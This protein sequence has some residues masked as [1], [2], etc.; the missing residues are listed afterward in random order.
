[1][2]F[3]LGVE[4][5]ERERRDEKGR[6]A[7]PAPSGMRRRLPFI[8]AQPLALRQGSLEPTAIPLS[9]LLDCLDVLEQKKR[10]EKAQ[11]ADSFRVENLVFFP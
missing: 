6:E 7:L 11:L 2:S 4:L 1:M 9:M 5:R 8:S 3:F 10:E